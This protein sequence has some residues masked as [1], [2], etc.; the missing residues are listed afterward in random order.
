MFGNF[1]EEA[2]KVLI[3]SKKEMYE[4][5][6]PY[7]GSEHLFLSILKNDKNISSKLEEYNLTYTSFKNEIINI[8][9]M[10]KEIGKLKSRNKE[11]VEE[12][13]SLRT[14]INN[15]L[16]VIKEFFR[17]LL[18]IGNE[19]TKDEV[20]GQVKEYYDN[21][22]FNS[23]DIYDIAKRTDKEDELFDYVN[24]PDYYKSRKSNKDKD[25]YDL[26]L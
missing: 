14:F 17:K 20:V 4:L 7:V 12:N 18:K 10:G 16:D 13:T 22:D 6:H 3:D 15:I 24:L 1:N 25:D 5:K 19:E 8:I 9:G 23:N 21:K 26:S 2:R 11:L